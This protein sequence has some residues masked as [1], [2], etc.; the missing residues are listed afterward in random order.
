MRPSTARQSVVF[1]D[2]FGPMT[3][4][5]SP[6]AIFQRNVFE[7][8][9]AGKTQ[10]RVIEANN[11]VAVMRRCWWG[12]DDGLFRWDGGYRSGSA[13]SARRPIGA[14]YIGACRGR[15]LFQGPPWE[16]GEDGHA[17]A[18]FTARSCG[19]FW[20]SCTSDTMT[21]MWSFFIFLR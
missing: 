20:F 3:P 4:T 12:P 16:G 11:R 17:C 6:S 18:G 2:P 8:D 5:N 15:S 21:L 14:H 1:P 7:S 13:F 9:D 19:S 10:R